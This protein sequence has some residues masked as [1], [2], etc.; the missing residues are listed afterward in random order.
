M[1]RAGACTFRYRVSMVIGAYDE[2][3]FP[4]AGATREF[5]TLKAA[6]RYRDHLVHDTGNPV[7]LQVGCL[8]WLSTDDA[9]DWAEEHKGDFWE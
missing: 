9:I 8:Q 1:I 2:T 7:L 5:K 3:V 4:G 6:E